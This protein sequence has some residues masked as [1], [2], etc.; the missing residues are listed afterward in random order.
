MPD[1]PVPVAR[2]STGTPWPVALIKGPS[3]V[4]DVSEDTPPDVRTA[5]WSV[6]FGPF[7]PGLSLVEDTPEE[8]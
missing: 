2:A 1:R 8:C 7:G 5:V 4:P 6:W 3:T